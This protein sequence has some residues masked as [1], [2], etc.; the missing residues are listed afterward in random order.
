MQCSRLWFVVFAASLLHL[1]AAPF[2]KVEES[3][4]LQG[5]HDCMLHPFPYFPPADN[6]SSG[7]GKL[8][9]GTPFDHLEF[10]GVVPR[11]FFGPLALALPLRPLS[12]I[13]PGL[14]GALRDAACAEGGG[15]GG[16]LPPRGGLRELVCGAL[17]DFGPLVT[18]Q[19]KPTFRFL[20]RALLSL[21]VVGSL[22]VLGGAVRAVFGAGTERWFAVLTATQ[23]HIVFYASRTLPNTFAL[24]LVNVVLALWLVSAA[25]RSRQRAKDSEAGLRGLFW[26]IR[27]LAFAGLVLR[28]ELAA[29]AIPLLLDGLVRLRIPFWRTFLVGL[30]ASLC[31]VLATVLVDSYFW[32]RWLW[33]EA[34]VLWFNT[35]ENRSAEWGTLPVWWYFA[36]ALPKALLGGIVLVPLGLL[37]QPRTRA[38]VA[39][40]VAFVALYSLLP[41]KELRFVFYAVPALTVVAGAGANAVTGAFPRSPVGRT[42]SKLFLGCVVAGSIAATALLLHISMN[43]YA[44]GD[45]FEEVHSMLQDSPIPRIRLHIDVPAAMTGVSRFGETGDPARWTYSKDE[46]LAAQDLAG[47]GFTHALS[48]ES[49]IP[50]FRVA[51]TIDGFAGIDV[52]AIKDVKGFLSRS[53]AERRLPLFKMSPMIYVHERAKRKSD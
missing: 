39:P 36:V 43:N 49:S 14:V 19:L 20:A 47:A 17:S 23:F 8:V 28:S 37:L 22:A 10:P 40:V 15:G 9:K 1:Y 48:A 5:T 16:V 18:A 29:L 12:A 38:F 35:V 6:T 3:F 27:I 30:I 42:V 34:E 46:S 21:Y 44:G 45:A 7:S 4:A 52:A 53:V 41:H 24:V 2:T 50:G 11:S 51:R 33:P 26:A 13:A 25:L 32:R 31:S